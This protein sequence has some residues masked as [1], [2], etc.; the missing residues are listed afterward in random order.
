MKGKRRLWDWMKGDDGSEVWERV[1]AKVE[2]GES[3]VGERLND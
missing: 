2:D 1:K 3:E